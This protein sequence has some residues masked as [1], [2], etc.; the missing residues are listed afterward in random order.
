MRSKR[1]CRAGTASLKQLRFCSASVAFC[2]RLSCLTAPLF[3]NRVTKRPYP[4]DARPLH[5]DARSPSAALR[6]SHC[7]L[8]RG[9][10]CLTT[11]GHGNRWRAKSR[12]DWHPIGHRISR[13]TAM[14]LHKRMVASVNQLLRRRLCIVTSR[15]AALSCSADAG[16]K[17]T[18]LAASVLRRG[19]GNQ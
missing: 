6:S 4:T 10:V 1:E 2:R 9:I 17:S 3:Q 12:G 14:F 13:L 7:R 5:P 16:A 11:I 18:D 8:W 15:L 19:K